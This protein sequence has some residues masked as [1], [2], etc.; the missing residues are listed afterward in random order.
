MFT[1]E[2][3]AFVR[4]KE[5]V[6]SGTM[7]DGRHFEEDLD[8]LRQSGIAEAHHGLMQSASCLL[9]TRLDRE[10]QEQRAR[11]AEKQ[12]SERVRREKRNARWRQNRAN[13]AEVN[14]A[15]AKDAGAGQKSGNGRGKKRG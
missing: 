14:R 2:S 8:T 7:T 5:A 13:R 11:V 1:P 15:R 12:G 4:V 10:R 9:M 3:S 6:V